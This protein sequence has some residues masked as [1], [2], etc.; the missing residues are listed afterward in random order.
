MIFIAPR[1]LAGARDAGNCILQLRCRPL[2][3]TVF[4]GAW[5]GSAAGTGPGGPEWV[6]VTK[7][8]PRFG[9]LAR[10][11]CRSILDCS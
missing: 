10:E 1:E 3:S 5:P 2:L 11:R 6:W 7:V 4:F 9:S 8:E